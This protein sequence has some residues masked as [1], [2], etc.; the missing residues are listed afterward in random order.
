MPREG[1]PYP[2][3]V[4]CSLK[5][6]IAMIEQKLGLK[7]EKVNGVGPDPSGNVTIA[8]DDSALTVEEDASQHLITIG[9]D[10]A[11]LP[12]AAVTS[13]NGET[14]AVSLNASEIPGKGVNKTVMDN[15]NTLE[16]VGLQM[17]SDLNNEI[18]ARGNADAALQTNINNV[19]ASLPGAAAA[20]VAADPTV[21]GLIAADAQNVKLSGNQAISD[22]KTVSTE[23][24]GTYSSQIANSQKVRNEISNLAIMQTGNQ[25]KSG[26]LTLASGYIGYPADWHATQK[27][28][29][30][31]GDYC[32]FAKIGTDYN[33]RYLL[34]DF[35][36]NSNTATAYGR[37][38]IRC[39]RT[40]SLPIWAF[41]KTNGSN[42]PLSSTS[43]HVLYD[44]S[45]LYLAWKKENPYG[46][47]RACEIMDMS[48]GAVQSPTS[49]NITWYTDAQMI[50]TND[51]SGYTDVAV[52]E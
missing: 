1:V 44:A 51:I 39:N 47:V 8:S 42:N 25:T 37:L 10:R 6:T 16:T 40:G 45:G 34:I 43:I 14:G 13:V 20:A 21:Q 29:M 4:L 49:S 24:T 46:G 18:T 23:A 11:E 31:T 38:G 30:N 7:I 48:Y 27:A 12:S 22:I 19:T 3:R 36:Q 26:I 33:G 35:L 41:R 32:I 50:V 5:N 2:E 52:V 17:R 15:I 9:L 28:E